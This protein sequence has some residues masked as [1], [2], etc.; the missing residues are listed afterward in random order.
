MFGLLGGLVVNDGVVL[1]EASCWSFSSKMPS[2][3]RILTVLLWSSKAPDDI[4]PLTEIQLFRHP[5]GDA[6]GDPPG[7]GV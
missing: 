1:I 7:L 3:H 4:K 6:A 2:G 5:G